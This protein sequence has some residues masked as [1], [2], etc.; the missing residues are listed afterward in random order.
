MCPEWSRSKQPLVKTTL[1]PLRFSRPNRKIASSSVKA[2]DCKGSPCRQ[3]RNRDHA[4]TLI[5][6][7][8]RGSALGSAH[9]TNEITTNR[10]RPRWKLSCRRRLRA[11]VPESLS[12]EDVFHSRRRLPAGN[13]DLR[14]EGRSFARDGRALSRARRQ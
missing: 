4:S 3:K 11:R 12:R 8:A 14:K 1:R 9:S 10:T 13:D 5:L 2:F 7:R 6:S